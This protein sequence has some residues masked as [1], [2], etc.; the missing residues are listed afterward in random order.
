MKRNVAYIAT[1]HDSVYAFDADTGAQLSKTSF[2]SSDTNAT[3]LIT[4]VLSTD[5]PGSDVDGP[6]VGIQSTPAIDE[7]TGTLYVVAKI[8]ETGRG[9]GNI[10]YV[11]RLHALDVATGAEKFGGPKVIGDTTCNNS[12]PTGGGTSTYDFN[13]AA[14]PQTSS[15]SGQRRQRRQRSRCISTR[16]AISQAAAP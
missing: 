6:D 16:C 10:H 7:S 5:L 8:K 15:P 1:M 14:N 9:D 2:I 4:T 3:P 13:L 11:Q 12:N